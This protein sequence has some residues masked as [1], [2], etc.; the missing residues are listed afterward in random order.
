MLM[1]PAAGTQVWLWCRPTDMRKG[2]HTLAALVKEVLLANPYSGHVFVFRG[3]RADSMKAL[4]WDETGLCL[5]A[6]RM[7]KGCF[8]WPPV[9]DE[10]TC[11]TTGQL[12][13]LIEGMNWK[14]TVPIELEYR[15]ALA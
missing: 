12:A 3:K 5:F 2:V 13:L 10:R 6:K 7:E 9:I 4:Y 14:R 8:V 11:L 15:P 1:Q